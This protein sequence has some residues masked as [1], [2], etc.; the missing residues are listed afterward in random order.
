[1]CHRTLGGNKILLGLLEEEINLNSF[2][3]R[4]HNCVWQWWIVIDSL[5]FIE[6]SEFDCVTLGRCHRHWYHWGS[7]QA[8]CLAVFGI[9][10]SESTSTTGYCKCMYHLQQSSLHSL[11]TVELMNQI[12]RGECNVVFTLD[13]SPS[14]HF[15]SQFHWCFCLPLSDEWPP[16]CHC[17][18]C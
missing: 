2:A 12:I 13:G 18:A 16:V 17:H 4:I 3:C 14:T 7:S 9:W 5:W 11:F 10:H 1:M 6:L 15:E 8:V